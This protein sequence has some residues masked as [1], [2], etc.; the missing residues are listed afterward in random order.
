M[1]STDVE[2]SD[3]GCGV[4]CGVTA[5]TSSYIMTRSISKVNDSGAKGSEDS[6]LSSS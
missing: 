1:S 6:E 3:G 2:G 4:T 5:T